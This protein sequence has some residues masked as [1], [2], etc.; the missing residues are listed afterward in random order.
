VISSA[1]SAR[2]LDGRVVVVTGAGRG[3]GRAHALACAAQG[4]RVLVND[5][6]CA[7]DGTGADPTVAE[8]V[9]SEI[10]AAGG[11]AL[12]DATDAANAEPLIARALGELGRVDA[13]IAAAGITSDRAVLKMDDAILERMI[14]LHVR[15]SFA[16]VR[17]AARAMIDAQGA[18]GSIVLHT[19]PV[20]FFGALRQSALA[21][22]T[23]ATAALARSAAIELRKHRIRVN[24]IAPT[25]RTRATED[26]PLFRG[27]APESMGPEFVGPLGA[28]LCSDLSADVSG[29]VVGA[30]G[31]RLYAL[32]GRETPGWFGEGTPPT[33]E[34]IARAWSEIT[35]A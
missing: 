31:T 26:L 28:F 15:G 6:G 11:T 24:A 9:A 1:T 2:I 8:A 7:L 14:A 29:E 33:P 25:A 30:A 35:R 4:A 12:A 10:R 5:L 17:A 23:A 18:G 34:A 22:V 13:V 21:A 19:A 3:V 27:I 16:L 32:R 20:A